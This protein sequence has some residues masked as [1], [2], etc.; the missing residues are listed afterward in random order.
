MPDDPVATAAGPYSIGSD[1]WPGLSKLIEECGEV[2]QVAGKIIATN[3]ETAHWDGTDL[4]ER[5][6]D[7]LGDLV[8]AVAFVGERNHL[9]QDR[10]LARVDEKS[11]LFDRWHVEQGGSDA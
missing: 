8:A 4:R 2:I 11:D 7:E 9:D 3:G 6:Q 1:H 10:V 5:L